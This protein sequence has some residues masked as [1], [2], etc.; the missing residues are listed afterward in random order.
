MAYNRDKIFANIGK[1]IARYNELEDQR[2]DL[3]TIMS[4]HMALLTDDEG[5]QDFEDNVHN[6]H[7]Q[8]L[9]RID[10]GRA[11]IVSAVKTYLTNGVAEDLDVVQPSV[12]KVLDALQDEMYTNGDTVKGW[13]ELPGE[14]AP[15][16]SPDFKADIDN[17]GYCRLDNGP[18][19]GQNLKGYPPIDWEFKVY[20]ISAGA[21]LEKWRVSNTLNR[22]V[23]D[24][25]TGVTGY[26]PEY[27]RE[28]KILTET[29]QKIY[30]DGAAQLSNLVFS[31]Q[32]VKSKGDG[33]FQDKDTDFYG[34]LYAKLY[35]L[36]GTYYFE[37]YKDSARTVKVASGTR[38]TATGTINF[39]AEVG[40]NVA[41]SVDIAY[42]VDDVDITILPL[43]P[44][45]IGDK[46][47][48]SESL[49]ARDTYL[50]QTFFSNVLEY[51][52]PA[53][54]VGYTVNEDFAKWGL[55]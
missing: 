33:A 6:A 39:T 9:A 16:G 27:G 18:Y 38:G 34:F 17:E 25:T 37:L 46:M 48:F 31:P 30:N 55:P 3:I 4:E 54:T 41:G 49:I 45:A 2:D 44:L 11:R 47:H 24:L 13:P 22:N 36:A 50:F 51:A 10:S 8:D 12:E 40:Y 29:V 26:F 43:L 32:P 23:G 52:M 28:F 1:S 14:E 7:N 20:D 53:L 15:V 19:D 21:G 35:L 5:E 42:T